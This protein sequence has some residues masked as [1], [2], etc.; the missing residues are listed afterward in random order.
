MILLLGGKVLLKALVS[1]CK[2]SSD[3]VFLGLASARFRG[4]DNTVLI[5]DVA[6]WWLTSC[7]GVQNCEMFGYCRATLI[8]HR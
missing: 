6:G 8:L 4:P 5:D 7:L 3:L 1:L 2:F